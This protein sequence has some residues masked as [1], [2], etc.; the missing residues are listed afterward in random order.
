MDITCPFCGAAAQREL[1]C[2]KCGKPLYEHEIKKLDSEREGLVSKYKI[3]YNTLNRAERSIKNGTY[4]Y[5][6]PPEE[7]VKILGEVPSPEKIESVDIIC[8]ANSISCSKLEY[9][10]PNKTDSG[11]SLGDFVRQEILKEYDHYQLGKLSK[12]R[13]IFV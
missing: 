13:D 4:E 11:K 5:K 1:V 8:I 10:Y 9:Y 2:L 6:V 3:C 7:I 12:L